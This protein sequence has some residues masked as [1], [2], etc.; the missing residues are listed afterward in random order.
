V[1]VDCYVSQIVDGTME[2]VQTTYRFLDDSVRN[3]AA[4]RTAARWEKKAADVLDALSIPVFLPT[5]R[6][7]VRYKT[8]KASSEIPIFSGYLFFDETRLDDLN[9]LSPPAKKYMAQVLRTPDQ[10][11]LNSELR[12]LASVLNDYELIQSKMFGAIGDTVRVKTG[13]FS[14]YEGQIVRYGATHNRL[15]LSVSY[16][17]LSVEVEIEDRNVEKIN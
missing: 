13:V 5:F 17:G 6:R 7:I 4:I 12:T 2:A 8:R 14:Q 9:R 1:A 16:L 11:L 15:V 10:D 3:W